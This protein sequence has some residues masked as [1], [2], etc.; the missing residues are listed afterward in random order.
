[1]PAHPFS[2]FEKEIFGPALNK[3]GIVGHSSPRA[4]NSL[5][6]KGR[7]ACLAC[8]ACKFC[9]SGARYSPDRVHVPLLDKLP[10]VSILEN[11]SL[12]KLET[13]ASGN[14]II[15][16]HTIRIKEKTPL[17]VRAKQFVLAI[18]GLETPRMLMLSSDNNKHKN[19]LGN[20][21]GQLGV[22]FS[23]HPTPYITYD[24]GQPVGR[25]LGYETM[26]TDYFREKI[27]RRE[28]PTFE[29][30]AAP[31]MDIFP[32]GNEALNWANNNKILYLE[33]L[34]ANLPH[35]VTLTA[36]AELQG[37]GTVELDQS[38]LDAFGAPVAKV[39]MTMTDW[40]RRDP[41]KLG[42]IAHDLGEVRV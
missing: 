16:A 33:E 15:A 41:S 26:F 8:R 22:G 24:I 13:T 9:P 30:F 29:F 40:D 32:I 7:S 25:R 42:K 14:K 38:K 1:M 5:V 37:K 6:Y 36:M 20:M 3:L 21:G 34:R 39:T 17:I 18:G 4:I 35:M 28:Q 31:A 2:Y 10:N 12:R 11:I 19:G 23:D 27:D